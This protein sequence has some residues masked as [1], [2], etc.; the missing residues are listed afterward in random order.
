[1]RNLFTPWRYGYLSGGRKVKSCIFCTARDSRHDA[2]RLVVHRGRH[3]FVILNRFPYN[4]GHLMIVPYAHRS[5]LWEGTPAQ[6]SEMM[7]LASRCARVLK[8]AYRPDGL[9]LGMNLG[10]AA[11]A[12]VRGHFHLHLVPRWEGDTNFMTVVGRTRVIPESLEVTYRK[13]SS[14]LVARSA[15]PKA[16]KSA[17]RRS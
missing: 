6:Q 8:K 1:M 11:G 12:G 17:R 15:R 3:N 9:N 14:K 4:N 13:I 16:G 5:E 2:S 10:A 7:T